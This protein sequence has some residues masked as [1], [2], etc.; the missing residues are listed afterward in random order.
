MFTLIDKLVTKEGFA[1]QAWDDRYGKGVWVAIAF[2]EYALDIV[3]DLSDAGDLDAIPATDF[4][5]DSGW[6][7]AVT[8]RTLIDA[9]TQLEARLASLPPEQLARSSDWS[10][11]VSD[12][13]DYLRRANDQ[14]KGYGAMDG[15]LQPLPKEYSGEMPANF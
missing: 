4:V 8:G 12:A 9:M 5:L 10:G 13:L 2:G 11:A 1:L 14:C 7:P 3:R 6:L 15:K